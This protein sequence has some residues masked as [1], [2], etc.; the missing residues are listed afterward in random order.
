MWIE[1]SDKLTSLR[2]GLPDTARQVKQFEADRRGALN[3]IEKW[4]ESRQGRDE[5]AW[6][7]LWEFHAANRE[8]LYPPVIEQVGGCGTK[9]AGDLSH[10]Q[11]LVYHNLGTKIHLLTAPHKLTPG[12]NILLLPTEDVRQEKLVITAATEDLPTR[13]SCSS[14]ILPISIGRG[15]CLVYDKNNKSYK[16]WVSTL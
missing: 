3:G 7:P 13:V 12:S 6:A 2:P 10:T 14:R 4:A 9:E 5:R 16:T 8:L 15:G 1:K 11:R